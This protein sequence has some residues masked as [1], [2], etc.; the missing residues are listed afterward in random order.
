M[1][2]IEKNGQEG[3]EQSSL[4]DFFAAQEGLE[5]LRIEA[6]EKIDRHTVRHLLF[7]LKDRKVFPEEEAMAKAIFQIISKQFKPGMGL[8]T[9]TFTWDVGV[10]DPLRLIEP[11]EWEDAGGSF[12]KE[13]ASRN[14]RLRRPPAFTQQK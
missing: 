1:T 7:K 14:I 12:D 9:F 6:E 10:D 13:M 2:D 8:A 11:H 3:E 5:N 4:A